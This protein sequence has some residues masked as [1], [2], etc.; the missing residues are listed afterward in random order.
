MPDSSSAFSVAIETPQE[1]VARL[2]ELY[3]GATPREILRAAIEEFDGG[4]AAVSSFGAEAAI[5]LHL[6]SELKP[7][8]PIIFLET[9]MHFA[10]TLEYRDELI[11]RFK[12]TD[13]RNITPDEADRTAEDPKNLLW[14]TNPDACCAFRKTKPL[15]AA[16]QGFSAWVTGRKRMHGGDRLRLPVFEYDAQNDKYKVNPLASFGVDEVDAY[17]ERHDL[18]RHSLVAEGFPSIGCW[19]CTEPADDND[20]RAGRWAGRE[21]NECGIHLQRA[22]WNSLDSSEL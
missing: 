5:T 16:L 11:E 2:N 1:R 20:P 14:R 3:R 12:L 7:D 15:D 13:V 6:L 22:A 18:P 10:Q 19:P 21:K 17:F 9:G 4:L 8:M